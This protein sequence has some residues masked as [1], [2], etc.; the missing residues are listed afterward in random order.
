MMYSFMIKLLFGAA[1]LL[2]GLFCVAA[3]IVGIYFLFVIFHWIFYIIGLVLVS[4]LIW[5]VGDILMKK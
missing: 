3:I 5:K 4:L 1:V 2:L